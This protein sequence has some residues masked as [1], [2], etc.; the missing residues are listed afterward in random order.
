M[1]IELGLYEQL[2]NKLMANKLQ[3]I[4][5][6]SFFIKSTQLDKAEASRYLSLYLANT[7]QFALNGLKNDDDRVTK[8]IELSNNI[9]QLLVKELPNLNLSENLIDNEGKNFT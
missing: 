5:S 8:Q 4:D 1:P 9:I 2:I 6:N 3:S 7:I